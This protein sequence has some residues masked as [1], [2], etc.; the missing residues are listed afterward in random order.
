MKKNSK[1]TP[2]V[3]GLAALALAAAGFYGG[4]E[5]QK[6]QDSTSSAGGATARG[7]AAHRPVRPVRRAT[8]APRRRPPSRRPGPVKSAKNGTLYVTTSDGTTVKVKT[9]DD[10]TVTRNAAT[11]VHPGD[12]VVVTGKI[13]SSGTVTATHATASAS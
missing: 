11:E 12:T 7:A 10:S 2:T 9:T 5:V 8:T 3:A 13:A 6:G 4:V 1:T